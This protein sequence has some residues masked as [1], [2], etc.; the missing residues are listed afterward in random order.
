MS[1]A[2]P[3]RSIDDLPGPPRLPF[4]GNAHRVRPDR[5][6]LIAEEWCERYGPI[7]RFDIGPRRIVAIGDEREI[8]AILRERPEEYRRWRELKAILAEMGN[9]GVFSAEGEDWKRQR[10]LA[11]TALN[12]NHLQRYFH[13][14]HTA[15]G[16]LYGRLEEAA[17]DGRA[18]D[19]V[20][21]LTSFSVDGDPRGG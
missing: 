7:F 18:L 8:N 17:R 9:D 19:I 14:I 2:G 16:R 20:A 1:T 3:L 11:V 5:L 13:I 4:I 21:E 6:H 15:T 12:S 10:R